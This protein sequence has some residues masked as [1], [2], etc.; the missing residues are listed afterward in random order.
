M[1]NWSYGIYV[2]L[3][4]LYT[5]VKTLNQVVGFLVLICKALPKIPHIVEK[6]KI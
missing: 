2:V 6:W 4:Y 1:S 5:C 3:N